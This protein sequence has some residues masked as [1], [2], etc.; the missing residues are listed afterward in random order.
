M[1]ATAT[2]GIL[3]YSSSLYP[4]P[5]TSSSNS[6]A[7]SSSS[8]ASS[9]SRHANNN[10]N[11]ST[12]PTP[13]RKI[14]FAPLPDPR[15]SFLDDGDEFPMS[16]EGT[17]SC[18]PILAERDAIPSI[19]SLAVDSLS[20]EI[21]TESD[22]TS[23]SSSRAS[24]GADSSATT[25]TVSASDSVSSF[26][27]DSPSY[28][29][30]TALPPIPNPLL[31]AKLKQFE[32]NSSSHTSWAKPKLI[33]RPFL[34]RP[35][36][37]SGA[38]PALLSSSNSA[39]L[40]SAS[41]ST[42]TLHPHTKHAPFPR[43]NLSSPSL[44]L[45]RVSSRHRHHDDDDYSDDG[46]SNGFMKLAKWTSSSSSVN[47]QHSHNHFHNP[48]S[49]LNPLTRTQSRGSV[50]SVQINGNHTPFGSTA[51]LPL[52]R[53]DSGRINNYV[54]PGSSLP[55]RRPSTASGAI[56]A[57]TSPARK[58]KGT[59]M[60]NGRVYG[61]RRN[62]SN[63]NGNP[64]ANARDEADPEFVEWGYGGMGSV[65]NGSG[66][67]HGVWGRLQSEGT[68]LGG[69]GKTD[70]E[71]LDDGSGMGWVRK[72]RE[73]KERKER[74]EQERLAKEAQAQLEVIN[75]TG[76]AKVEE[77]KMEV[78]E[79]KQFVRS[80][81]IEQVKDRPDTAATITLSSL[82]SPTLPSALS[83]PTIRN[84]VDTPKLSDDRDEHDT[85]VVNVSAHSPSLARRHSHGRSRSRDSIPILEKAQAE[86]TTQAVVSVDVK[87][88]EMD[89]SEEDEDEGTRPNDDDDE[90]SEEDSEN[91][92]D[93]EKRK[94]ALGAGVEKISRHK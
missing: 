68:A 49:P 19:S 48:A 38:T 34:R 89:E 42:S 20:S 80:D 61:H 35:H 62:S 52:T 4:F 54:R 18:P 79:E 53:V 65:R 81:E 88:E 94:T 77:A 83:T 67:G 21:D 59:R 84:D 30:K 74:E 9:S 7:S 43:I 6:V 36:S 73:Q 78:D 90:D 2:N 5:T 72:R 31:A 44:G 46:K 3:L 69:G 28:Q 71:E 13:Q 37:S 86:D 50:Q 22:S 33:F 39:N 10:A 93:A 8:G 56:S 26:T 27:Q 82:A 63:P 60:L 40:P 76:D 1:A 15:R 47:K 32:D 55:G 70:D 58:G 25:Q 11:A 91:E 14:R 75:E 23:R 85:R 64:F 66:V 16:D 45:F 17:I 92:E 57:P 87:E 51:S 41:S 12:P 24:K 29:T